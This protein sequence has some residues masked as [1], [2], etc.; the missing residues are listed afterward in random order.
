MKTRLK[1]RKPVNIHSKTLKTYWNSHVV[2]Y[3]PPVEVAEV[4]HLIPIL[5]AWGSAV[6]GMRSTFEEGGSVG[7]MQQLQ[8]AGYPFLRMATVATRL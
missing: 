8:A 4:S 6:L 1:P 3:D 5:L 2:F 7:Q